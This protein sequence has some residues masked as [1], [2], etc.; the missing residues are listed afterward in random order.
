MVTVPFNA[1][2]LASATSVILSA[3]DTRVAGAQPQAPF[4]ITRVRG[5]IQVMSDQTIVQEGPGGAYGIMIVNG[6]AFDAGVASMPTPWTE[7]FDARWLYHTYLS[8]FMLENATTSDYQQ[9]FF[10]HVIDGKAMRKVDHGDVI[11][12]VLENASSV[13]MNHWTNFR[14]G[15]KLH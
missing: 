12:A 5:Y 13:G 10:T 4:T 11:V 7:S 1:S 9:G 8:A 14:T 6:E 3:F 15:V 2:T